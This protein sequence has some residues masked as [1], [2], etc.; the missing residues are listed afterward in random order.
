[1]CSTS[2]HIIAFRV[3]WA[4][5]DGKQQV[6]GTAGT[7]Y[8]GEHGQAAVRGSYVNHDTHLRESKHGSP[9]KACS[10]SLAARSGR[11]QRNLQRSASSSAQRRIC[12]H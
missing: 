1:M 8:T 3:T 4:D 7:Y 9:A 10:N 5:D 2:K 11:E 6:R 12:W